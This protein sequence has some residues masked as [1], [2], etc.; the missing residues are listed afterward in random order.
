MEDLKQKLEKHFDSLGL[1]MGASVSKGA[2][3]LYESLKKGIVLVPVVSNDNFFD[4][5]TGGWKTGPFEVQFHETKDLKTT[6]NG[7]SCKINSIDGKGL[8]ARI[9]DFFQMNLIEL[10]GIIH[11]ESYYRDSFSNS[12]RMITM[13]CY[14]IKLK[15]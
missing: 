12:S 14:S 8:Y 11:L 10:G 7:I 1:T 9:Q 5:N 6:A 13:T 2:K 3:V 15:K 4:G